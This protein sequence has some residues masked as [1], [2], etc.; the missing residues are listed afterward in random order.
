MINTKGF[1]FLGKDIFKNMEY[2][3]LIFASILMLIY[4]ASY[5]NFLKSLFLGSFSGFISFLIIA[6][7]MPEYFKCTLFNF[8]I[9]II[10]G[11]FGIVAIVS[12]KI[13]FA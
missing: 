1:I 11:I 5:K 3:L 6:Y 10:V 12:F 2:V 13:F 9:S 7:F 4:Y 8:L